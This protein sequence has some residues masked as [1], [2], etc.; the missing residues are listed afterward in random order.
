[1]TC[2]VGLEHNGKVYMGGDS[3]GVAGWS[4]TVRADEKVFTNGKFLIGYT[5]SFRMGQLLRYS[6]KPPKQKAGTDDMAYLV[7]H[8][9]DEVRKCFKAGGILEK[10]N[11]VES[12]GTWLVGYKG[13]LYEIGG[14]FQVGR[15]VSGY[16]SVGCGDDLALGAMYVTKDHK[17]PKERIRLALSASAYHNGGVTPPFL[18][19]SM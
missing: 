7:T 16:Q 15:P 18:I 10:E 17:D 6:F 14:D 4:L 1:M 3:A 9:I 12:G 2:I 8:F 11:N 5:S 13:K 19:L